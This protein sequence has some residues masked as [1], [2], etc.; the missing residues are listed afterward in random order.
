MRHGSQ[1]EATEVGISSLMD[2]WILLRDI[3]LA[4]ERNRGIY[5]LKSRGMKHSNQIREFLLTER[6]VQ[7][8]DV[9]L[10]RVRRA[11]RIGSPGGGSRVGCRRG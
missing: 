8:R 5:V 10:G 1:L 2:T 3:E 11:D 4:G 7:L 9:Y 6:G